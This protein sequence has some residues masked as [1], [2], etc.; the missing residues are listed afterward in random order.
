MKL[1]K[2]LK[3]TFIILLIVFISIISFAGFYVQDKTSMRDLLKDY[4]L[5]MDLK[6]GR[7]VTVEVS[8]Q[9][10]TIYYD[11]DGK[12]VEEEKKDGTKKEV[13]VNSKESLT[14]ENYIKTKEIIA[15]RLRDYGIAEYLIGQDENTGKIT[16]QIPE[17]SLTELA[18]QYIYMTGKF[19]VLGENDE[20][21]LDHSDIKEAKA[22]YGSK[23]TGTQVYLE[24]ELNEASKEKLREMSNK[25][26]KTTDEDG[27]ETTKQIT[28]KLDDGNLKSMSFDKEV[29]DGILRIE[30]GSASTNSNTV[31]SYWQQANNLEMII[32][33]GELPLEYSLEQNRYVS[34]E[35]S[36]KSLTILM[37]ALLGFMIIGAIILGIIYKKNGI[38]TGIAG[39]GYF[40]LLLILIRYTNVVITTEGLF[41]ILTSTILNYIFSIYLLKVLKE[42][43]EVE[44][45]YNKTALAML[46]ILLPAIIVGIV[47]CYAGWMPIYSFGAS[48][49]WGIATIFIYNTVLTRTLLICSK[50]NK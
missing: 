42:G 49:F 2:G 4:Q 14:K 16:V 23:K 6:G 38:L 18:I 11:K 10:D 20:I 3:I 44:K 48:I 40:A 8:T 50:K 31:N 15:K 45:A 26:V 41:G 5:G 27:K 34:S 19:T 12:V 30:M 43:V 29:S 13:P 37:F 36:T 25:Y 17:D 39:I 28:I 22:T 21:L 1:D 24:L 46:L 33:H 7:I 32:N 35:I 47:L 9:T